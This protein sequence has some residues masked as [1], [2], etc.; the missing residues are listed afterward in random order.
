MMTIMAIRQWKQKLLKL[1]SYQ[2]QVPYLDDQFK[3]DE[4]FLP[5]P[6]SFDHC[7]LHF[8]YM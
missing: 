7:Y 8:G 1:W 4:L 2:C 5:R 6:N 3:Y